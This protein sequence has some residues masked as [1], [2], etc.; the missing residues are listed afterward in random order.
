MWWVTTEW[1]FPLGAYRLQKRPPVK[2][3]LAQSFTGACRGQRLLLW[4]GKDSM[5]AEMDRMSKSWLRVSGERRAERHCAF[6]NLGVRGLA[7]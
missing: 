5:F 2:L 1:P 7:E 6:G 4:G 3:N